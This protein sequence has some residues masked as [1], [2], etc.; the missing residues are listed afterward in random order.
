MI[1]QRLEAHSWTYELNWF[2][3]NLTLAI[4][5]R[6]CLLSVR[7]GKGIDISKKKKTFL[8]IYIWLGTFARSFLFF[9]F[10]TDRNNEKKL[11]L[12]VPV[13]RLI[14][15]DKDEWKYL[16]IRIELFDISILFNRRN[17]LRKDFFFF[18]EIKNKF[19]F[20]MINQLIRIIL[21]SFQIFLY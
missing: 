20:E 15:T 18:L 6:F 17:Q 8:Y 9:S 12:I 4:N 11:I 16:I 14:H 7:I 2:L 10:Q 1:I 21:F 3:H 5:I 19:S 13:Y